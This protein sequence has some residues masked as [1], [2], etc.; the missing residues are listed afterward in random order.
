MINQHLKGGNKASSQFLFG[1]TAAKKII[2]QHLKHHDFDF[3][4][5]PNPAYFLCRSPADGNEAL[6]SLSATV[7]RK[8]C[9]KP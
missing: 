9:S 8:V 2:H 6:S 4:L 3:G 1:N 5:K 7:L